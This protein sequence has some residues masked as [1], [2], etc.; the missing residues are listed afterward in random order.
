M[1]MNLIVNPLASVER[2]DQTGELITGGPVPGRGMKFL[3]ITSGERPHLYELFVD[4]E[5]IGLANLDV[6]SDLEN[7]EREILRDHGVLIESDNVPERPLFSCMLDTVDV[8]ANVPDRLI[9][10]PTLEFQPF[11]LTK[12]RSWQQDRHLSPHHATVWLN[13]PRTRSRWGYWLTTDQADVIRNLEPG[14]PAPEGLEPSLAAKLY[15]AE[16]LLS[17]T[18]PGHPG[19]EAAAEEFARD[20]YAVVSDILPPAQLRALQD[21]Y[22]RYVEQGFMKFGD[23][24]VDRR[25]VRHDEP[26]ATMLQSAIEPVMEKI[27]GVPI[28]RTYA[29]SAVYAEG[30]VLHPHVD[31]HA[32]EF[33]FSFQLEYL[34]E[35]SDGVSPWPLYIS[36]NG[37]D[38]LDVDPARDKAIH[39]PNG[40]FLA[41]KGRELVHY[42]TP[43]FP[44]HRSTSLFFHYVPA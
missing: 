21:Y 34:P 14:V 1:A 12:F 5:S 22:R 18:P 43:L 32:C 15:A 3:Q 27:T 2:T 37:P 42:R 4:L 17:E 26:V 9:V 30:A 10:N 7:G 39:L 23:N 20:R 36:V 11:D 25:F 19:L 6:E 33:S 29:Y 35:P 44:G 40:G 38:D 8:A 31:R 13:D 41:Y 16:V 24:Q 28:E